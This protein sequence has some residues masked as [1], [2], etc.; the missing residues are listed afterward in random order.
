MTL[1]IS[2]VMKTDVRTVGPRMPVAELERTLIS[3]RLSGFPVV[4]EEELVGVVSRSDIVRMLDVER[5]HEEQI[6]DYYRTWVPETD[7]ESIAGTGSRIGA[8]MEGKVV[9]DVMVKNVITCRAEQALREAAATLLEYD[10]HRLPITEKGRLVGI[11][12]SMDLVRVI[13]EGRS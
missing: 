13:A 11:V 10:I 4:E 1:S 9:A 8:R 2:D 12:T 6:S 5:A 3:H 7:A